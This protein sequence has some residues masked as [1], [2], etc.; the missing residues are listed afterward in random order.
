[1][2]LFTPKQEHLN[3]L[4]LSDWYVR[5]WKHL[6]LEKLNTRWGYALGLLLALGVAWMV[7]TQGIEWAWYAFSAV[8]LLPV[9]IASFL[10]PGAGVIALIFIGFWVSLAKRLSEGLPLGVMVDIWLI[11]ILGGIFFRQI[12]RKDWSALA[13]PLSIPIG[14]WML[15]C[16]L[17]FLN[18]WSHADLGWFYAF[19]SVAGW[20]L[21]YPIGV[22]TLTEFRRIIQLQRLWIGLV[23][24]VA[25]YGLW[26]WGTGPGDREF[27]WIMADPERFDL[28]F[29]GSGYRVFSVFSDPTAF[30]LLCGITATMTAIL[31]WRSGASLQQKLLTAAVVLVMVLATL[32]TESRIAILLPVAGLLFYTLL[33]LRREALILSSVLLA[34]WVGIL[35]IPVDH[36]VWQRAQKIADPTNSV[37]AEIRDQNQSW[38]QPFIL[39]HPIGAGLGK[40]GLLGQRFAPDVWLSQFPPDSA[41][42]RTALETGYIGLFLYL[43]MMASIL[44]V[45]IRGMFRAGSPRVKV[46]YQAWLTFAFLV[47]IAN[48][49]QQVTTQLPIGLL[50]IL[51]PAVF[52]ALHHLQPR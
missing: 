42:V 9:M 11:V 19:R 12:T 31:G 49:T 29:N 51:T 33:S 18:P 37:G 7:G 1:M 35:T 15:Y 50:F 30:G 46:L 27:A 21:L 36:A 16:G 8:L 43:A 47:V 34:I 20:L 13:H 45:G 17:E 24:M 32:A 14:L 38:V 2:K 44:V 39:D 3:W 23:T 22:L 52:V 5:L 10:F 28:L 26:Q 6:L 40:T 41:Y 48:Y 4:T 25:L